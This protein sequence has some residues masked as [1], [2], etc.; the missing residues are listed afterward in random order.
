MKGKNKLIF[1]LFTIVALVA[2]SVC[3]MFRDKVATIPYASAEEHE[4]FSAVLDDGVIFSAERIHIAEDRTKEL[5]CSNGYKFNGIK[6]SNRGGASDVV[7]YFGDYGLYN[8][9]NTYQSKDVIRDG[10]FVL[11]DNKSVLPTLEGYSVKQGIIVTFGSYVYAKDGSIVTNAYKEVDGEGNETDV[12]GSKINYVS[13]E[14]KLNGDIITLP[15]A[16][17]YGN[18]SYQDFTWFI[19]PQ[20]DDE[21]TPENES[22]EGHYEISISYMINGTAKRFE[23]DFYLLLNS[24]YD[25]EVKIESAGHVNSYPTDPTM[26]NTTPKSTSNSSYLRYSYFLGQQTTYPT[27][28]FDYTRYTLDYVYNSGDVQKNVRFNYNA[29]TET[30]ELTTSLYN[31]DSTKY[32]KLQ[33][34]SNSIVTLMFVDNGKYEFDFKYIYNYADERVVIDETQIDYPNIELDI[35]GYQLKYSKSGYASADLTYLE[36]VQNQTMFILVNGFTDAK[37]EK[38]GSGLG[39]QYKLINA[40]ETENNKTSATGT[41]INGN[42]VNDVITGTTYGNVVSEQANY[43]DNLIISGNVKY[44]KTDRGLWFNLND[45][46]YLNTKDAAGAISWNSYYYFNATEK[47]T[48]A[49]KGDRIEFTK[50]TTFTMPGYY[51]IQVAYQYEEGGNDVEYQYFAF[52]ITSA[53]PI[54]NLYKTTAESFDMVDNTNG[55]YDNTENFYAYEYTNQNVFAYWRETGIF[56][57]TI[58]GKLYYS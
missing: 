43:I 55:V 51:L 4:G 52:Q 49:N 36:I 21:T 45:R 56:E 38:M 1:A 20:A 39:V 35:Y 44:P 31:T 17:S 5:S 37:A 33:G 26:I 41:I 8:S 16:R 3:F 46:F 9:D 22:T 54:L 19:I 34:F 2:T 24:L 48:D 42:F 58:T 47:I 23:F 7:E 6:T 10:D 14:A 28:T 11:V 29:E 40:N 15:S 30:L 27:L 32:Y 13:A 50:I 12:E 18:S 25:T 53:T 57:S